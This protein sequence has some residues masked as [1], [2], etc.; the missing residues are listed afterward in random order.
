MFKSMLFPSGEVWTDCSDELSSRLSGVVLK[1]STDGLI[2]TW[3]LRGVI[4]RIKWVVRVLH[5][6]VRERRISTLCVSLF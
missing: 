3:R 6:F 5:G 1:I 2:E 4:G